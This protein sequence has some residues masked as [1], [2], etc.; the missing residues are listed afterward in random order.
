MAMSGSIPSIF[1]TFFAWAKNVQLSRK[2][3]W[4][5]QEG[6]RE[7]LNSQ[8]IDLLQP[9]QRQF[10]IALAELRGSQSWET[11][12][13]AGLTNAKATEVNHSVR[14][15]G[16]DELQSQS[17]TLFNEITNRKRI[18]RAVLTFTAVGG[19]LMFWALLSGP[20]FSVYRQYLNASLNTFSDIANHSVEEFPHPSPSLLLTSVILSFLPMLIY[21]MVVM[22]LLLRRS[23]ILHISKLIYSEQRK[24]VEKL[25]D[26]G[27][28]RLEFQDASLQHAHFLL[29]LDRST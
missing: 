1:G 21:A 23:K 8:A 22:T 18:P 14:L 20:I 9:I 2:L 15:A 7:R 25:Q 4:D 10:H 26:D 11:N 17:Q 12:V 16:I 13:T 29:G 3:Q 5:I 28:L 24:L 27:V 6:L 19:L